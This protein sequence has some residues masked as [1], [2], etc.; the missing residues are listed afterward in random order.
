M[1]LSYVSGG[2]LAIMFTDDSGV[3]EITVD[4]QASAQIPDVNWM[5][6]RSIPV[7][8]GVSAPVYS[9]MRRRPPNSSDVPT[10][11]NPLDFRPTYAKRLPSGDVLIVNGYVGRYRKAPIDPQ[12]P[13]RGEIIGVDG[14]F[15]PN[16]DGYGFNA[17]A[18]NLGFGSLSIKFELPPVNGTR[19]LVAPTFADRR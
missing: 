12:S 17:A 19:G 9:V 11:D 5:L 15:G 4:P 1:S 13:F 8:L 18:E 2:I 16:T 7:S 6:P 10:T 3:Y 14:T